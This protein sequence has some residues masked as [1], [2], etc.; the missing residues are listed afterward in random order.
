M[1][2]ILLSLA[3]IT[4]SIC[5]A[6]TVKSVS[7]KGLV[8]ISPQMA[9]EISA[10]NVGEQF[11]YEKGNKA[12][13]KLFAQGYFEDIWIEEEDGNIII[14]VKEKPTIAYV[15]V[16][17]V[18]DD[19]AKNIKAMLGVNKGMVYDKNIIKIAKT[20]I[21]KYYEAKGY[22]D[23]IVEEIA[24]PLDKE[25]SSLKL[26]FR[27]N[28]GENIIIRSVKLSGAKE[29]DYDD[30]E[31]SLV[32]KKRE[33]FGWM[34]GFNDGK[35]R[36]EALPSDP[37][38]IKDEYLKRGFLDVKVSNPYL[39]LY[40]D[41]YDANII[42][43]VDEGRQY[44]IDSIDINI[45][46]GI[47]N[48]E[49]LKDDLITKKGQVFNIQRV[50][51]DMTNIET[52]IADLG[53]A[54]VKVYPDIKQNKEK[55]LVS[56]VYGVVP[57]NKVTIRKVVIGGNLKTADHVIRRDLYLSEGELYSKTDLKDTIDTLKRTGYFKDVS[58]EEKRVSQNEIDLI[59]SV[60]EASTGSIKGGIGYGSTQGLMFDVGV[61]DKNIF[62]SGM[63]GSVNVSRSDQEL[64]G[65]INLT[66]PRVYDSPYSL[67]GSLYIEDNGWNSY[68]EKTKGASVT[69]GRKIGR[70]TYASLRYALEKNE[71]SKLSDD[72]LD[73]GYKEGDSVKS[74]LTPHIRYDN[75]DDYYLPRRG[76]I[77][78]TSFEYAGLGGD[79]KFTKSINNFKYFYGLED[80]IGYD[81]ILRYKAKLRFAMDKGYLPIDERLYLGGIDSV[82]GF[83]S[84]SIGPKKNTHE[85]G[86]K[87]SFNNS[88]EASFPLIKRIQMR[89]ALFYDYGM[90]GIDKMSE[91]QKSSVGVNLE[92]ISPL[93]AINLIFAKPLNKQEDDETSSFEFSIGRQF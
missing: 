90:I 41:N 89:W 6:T 28:R 73:L 60:K 77:A 71:L 13:Q 37:D 51:K 8:H 45:P 87:K 15:E 38:R 61:S 5:L 63:I 75:T 17:G 67:G 66:N 34:W 84:R 33:M 20:S 50:R 27:V 79:E 82:R 91:Y 40:Y 31:P 11:S 57:N 76:F 78:S 46:E 14:N 35:L 86:G 92:W 21:I 69:L 16:K 72:L 4:S 18:S 80:L 25:K 74:A 29:L 23:T 2:K 12:I 7:F 24:K 58:V 44:T 19:D 85:Y 30:V 70:H 55:S 10:I 81:I 64:S 62:G 83:V 43:K 59:V 48:I 88:I 36:L 39:R 47:V 52:K 65:K 93:G 54:F 32:N 68:D 49:D 53:Y 1:K 22:F 42:Y 9:T 3:F 56:I 26:S